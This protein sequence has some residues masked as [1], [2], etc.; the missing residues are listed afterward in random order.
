M[1]RKSA[2]LIA[3]ANGLGHSRRVFL[4]A[5][6]LSKLGWQVTAFLPPQAIVRIT[7][8]FQ[9]KI[10]FQ[11]ETFNTYTSAET[12][13]TG[14]SR[15]LNWERQLPSLN[16]YDFVLSDNLPEI[17]AV[18]SD[19]WLS[20]NF[21]WH[22]VLPEV[23]NQHIQRA[24]SLIDA[25]N[26]MLITY[27]GFS[28]VRDTSGLHIVECTIPNPPLIPPVKK[29]SA[30]L[31]TCGTGGKAFK[32][33]EEFIS[34]LSQSNADIRPF[35]RVFVEPNLLPDKAPCWMYPADFSQTMFEEVSVTIARPGFGIISDCTFYRIRLLA[36]AE[37]GNREM[38]ANAS[39]LKTLGIGDNLP[40][41]DAAFAQAKLDVSDSKSKE[42]IGE[43]FD[44]LARIWKDTPEVGLV[45]EAYSK[46]LAEGS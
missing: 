26:P 30:L 17:L 5:D 39:R 27:G 42:T 31:I 10:D 45:I 4:I 29:G 16:K 23:S 35:S 46:E 9:Q 33:Y 3:C 21:L 43:K 8:V 18:R 20:G 36:V 32:V 11:I 7:A 40:N 19:A 15:A 38:Q 24:K 25:H 1:A 22:E 12:L 14:D 28:S 6:Q 2:A 44:Q 41:L 13:C 34:R 37:S